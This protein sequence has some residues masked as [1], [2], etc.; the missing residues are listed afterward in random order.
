MSEHSAAEPV[1]LGIAVLTISD[2]RSISTDTSGGFLRDAALA[3]GHRV[4]DHAIVKDDIWAIRQWLCRC[5]AS[6]EVNVVL[7]TGGTGFTPRDVT[8]QAVQPLL[9]REIN[10]FGELF[11]Q[12]SFGE[13]GTSTLQSR[14]LAGLSNDTLVCCLPGSTNACRT[15]WE[16]ILC[17][18]LDARTKPC[19]FVPH[20]LRKQAAPCESRA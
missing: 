1:S 4:V 11:R 13:I 3:A 17:A 20:L 9:E 16:H 15:A 6:A 2:T 14:A 8:P 18:Q 7:M 19:N 10:G 12:V 5:I